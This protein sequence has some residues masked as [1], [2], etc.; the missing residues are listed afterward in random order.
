[1]ITAIVLVALGILALVAVPVVLALGIVLF[2][3]KLV[4]SLLFL[5]FRLVGWLIGGL[6]AIF[7][8]VL[9]LVV[10]GVV[11]VPVLPLLILG[12]IAY[13]LYRLLRPARI[14]TA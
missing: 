4:F 5:P 7:F 6:A 10:L 3:V 12:G 2:A 9:S 1:M 13:L 14:A 8:G 11:L